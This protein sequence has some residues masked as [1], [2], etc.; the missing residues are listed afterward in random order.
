M[1]GRGP[2]SAPDDNNTPPK[3]KNQAVFKEKAPQNTLKKARIE[4]NSVT[5]STPRFTRSAGHRTGKRKCLLESMAE[6]NGNLT[7]R[8]EENALAFS[9]KRGYCIA[10]NGNST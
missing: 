6:I 7:F 9:G 5:Y 4:R 2:P 10:A 1:H 8:K 3:H